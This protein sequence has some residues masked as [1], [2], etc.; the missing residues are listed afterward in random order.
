MARVISNIAAILILAAVWAG[1]MPAYAAAGSYSEITE[2]KLAPING[3]VESEI[4][5]GNIPG[6]VI[7]IGTPEKIIYRRAF[8]YRSIEPKRVPMTEDVIFDAASLTKVIATTTAVMQL[9]E[10]GKLDIDAL[11]YKYW[12]SL[13]ANG[14]KN[15]TVRHL[16]THYSGLKPDLKLKPKWSGCKTAIK[17][18]IRERPQSQPGTRFIYS[19]INFEILGEIVRRVSGLE[20]DAYCAKNIFKPLGMRDTTFKPSRAMRDR[21]APTEYHEGRMLHGEVH[22]PTCYRMGGVAGHAGLFSTAD[23]ISIFAQMLLNGGS[24]DNA[25]I[26]RPETI[27]KMTVPQ[28][29][30]NKKLRGFGWDMDAPFASN[31]DGLFPVGLYGHLGYTGTSLWIDPVSKIYVIVLTNRVHPNGKGD[32]KA[33]RAQIKRV[34]SEAAGPIAIEQIIAERPSLSAYSER[35]KNHAPQKQR[36]GKVMTGIDVLGTDNFSFLAGLRVGLITNHSGL[37]SK[38]RRTLELI[39]NAHGV[40]LTALFS[41]EH[42]LSGKMDEKIPS[43]IESAT[44]LPVYSLYGEAKRPA[45]KMLEGIDALV[46]DIQDAG[47]RFYTYITTM[48]YAMEA[49]A[50]KG[51]RFYVLDRPN[52]I[53]AA[54]VQGPV[55]DGDMRSFTGYFPLP[56]RHG[57]TVGELAA[58]FNAENNIGADLHIIKMRGYS[59]SDWYDDTGLKWVNPSPNLRSLTQV[60]LYPGVALVEGSNVS[61]GRGTD[62]P[63]EVFGAPWINA[64]ELAKY[65]EGRG[66]KGARFSPVSFTPSNSIYKNRTCNG[67]KVT[68]TDRQALDSTFLGIEIIT[69]LY[70]LYP[71]KFQLDKTL[72]LIGSRAVLQSIKEGRDPKSISLNWQPSLEEFLKLREKYL[73]Y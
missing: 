10:K 61:V 59:R 39:Y 18:I 55:M 37:D 14:K 54:F 6:A 63:F 47:V 26:L 29:P 30:A 15:I 64:K 2:G 56:V 57:M 50:K 46:F 24:I 8:G 48:G 4:N 17:M 27:E 28:S 58:M 43:T 5:S 34:V 35:M 19:D 38:G 3:I 65:L 52:P 11:A 33:L 51:I 73:L 72:G 49:A 71:E 67:V 36:N 70:K 22:D 25:R 20:L 62:T 9:A 7:L 16:L 21:I 40:K 60:I 31:R 12:P 69:A 66:I 44:G 68:I 1:F 32:V 45:D 42:G 13:K 23:D 53:N 41:P